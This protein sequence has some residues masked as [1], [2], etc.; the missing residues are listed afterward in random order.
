[1]DDNGFFDLNFLFQNFCALKD[2]DDFF[3]QPYVELEIIG[4]RKKFWFTINHGNKKQKFLYKKADSKNLYEAYG[5]ILAKEIAVLLDIPCADYMLA[6][7]DC[8]SEK[9]QD[10]NHS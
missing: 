8:K 9:T 1:M 10:F 2:T 3:S 6:K 5:E 4:K 7:F